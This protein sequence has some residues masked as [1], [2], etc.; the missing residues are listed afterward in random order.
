MAI[1]KGQLITRVVGAVAESHGGLAALH[2]HAILRLFLQE[3]EVTSYSTPRVHSKVFSDERS[4]TL[5]S[6]GAF[7]SN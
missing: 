1:H 5:N 4:L 2:A 7:M 6:S 3:D